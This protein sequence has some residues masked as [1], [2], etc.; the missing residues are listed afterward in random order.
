MLLLAFETATILSLLI[1]KAWALPIYLIGS[2]VVSYAIL[3]LW[4]RNKTADV[5]NAD[6]EAIHLKGN[7]E[8]EQNNPRGYQTFLP[9]AT[10][11]DDGETA[12]TTGDS[13]TTIYTSIALILSAFLILIALILLHL[14]YPQSVILL[15]AELFYR[16]GALI[17]GG[18][19][20][21]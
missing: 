21:L 20:V 5:E 16:I 14:V 17:Y 3:T 11:A 12:P 18:G 2:G 1:E 8:E 4:D 10:T 7:R 19:Q 13:K 15:L 6:K 9:V